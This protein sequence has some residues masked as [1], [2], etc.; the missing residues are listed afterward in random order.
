[1]RNGLVWTDQLPRISAG[2]LSLPSG[3]CVLDR[4]AVV[5]L[6]AGRDDFYALRSRSGAGQ[7]VLMGFDLLGLKGRDLRSW[8]L[9]DRRAELRHLLTRFTYGV[10]FVDAHDQ[11]GPDQG[12]I[13][14]SGKPGR[15]ARPGPDRAIAARPGRR[16]AHAGAAPCVLTNTA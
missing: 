4:E 6:A 3:S 14:S 7:A 11:H 12:L 8:P 15:K 9:V 2:L 13:R 5:Q 1:M 16:P 10:A